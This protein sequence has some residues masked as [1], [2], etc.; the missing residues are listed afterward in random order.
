LEQTLSPRAWQE[1][2]AEAWEERQQQGDAQALMWLAYGR[3]AEWN[4]ADRADQN[5]AQ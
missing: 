1:L 5:A 2:D 4:Q 3:R